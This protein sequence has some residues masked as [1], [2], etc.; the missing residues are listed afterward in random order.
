VDAK[1]SDVSAE[2]VALPSKLAKPYNEAVFDEYVFFS[3]SLLK[4]KSRALFTMRMSFSSRRYFPV[5][6]L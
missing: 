3:P 5:S 2:T 4:T 6:G 1:I